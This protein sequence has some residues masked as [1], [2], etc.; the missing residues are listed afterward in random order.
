MKRNL[1]RLYL[2][3]TGLLWSCYSS[4]VQYELLQGNLK[5]NFGSILENL[6]AQA[7]GSKEFPLF[8][9]DNKHIELDFVVSSQNRLHILE[10]KSGNGFMNH[11][12]LSKALENTTIPNSQ[13]IVQ[14]QNKVLCLP[15][16]MVMF[17]ENERENE[18]LLNQDTNLLFGL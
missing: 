16:Y 1:F 3:D 7:L 15:F 6:F 2:C 14:R 12:S 4:E 17:Y 5:V 10:I 18:Y 11:P 9:Y 8:Y 13:G